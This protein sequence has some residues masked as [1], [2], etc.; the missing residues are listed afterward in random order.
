MR[1]FAVNTSGRAE[2]PVDFIGT[3]RDL[4]KV[5]EYSDVVVVCLPLS[6]ATRGLIGERELERMRPD[7]ILINVARGEI[8]SEDALFSRLQS[9]PGFMAGID[10]WWIEPFR[11]GEFRLKHPFFSLPNFLGSPHNSAMTPEAA[12]ESVRR[13]VENVLR[14]LDGE[15]LRGVVK[16]SDYV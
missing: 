15:P 2:E 6:K 13:A 11:Q 7:A 5:L 3:L 10:A 4:E 16:R 12:R 1:I 14:F 8:V 9:H